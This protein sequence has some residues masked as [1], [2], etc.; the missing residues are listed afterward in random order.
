MKKIILVLVGFTTSFASILFGLFMLLALCVALL[1]DNFKAGLVQYKKKNYTRATALFAA[2][3]R[4]GNI[5][6]CRY[7]QVPLKKAAGVFDE[8]FKENMESTSEAEAARRLS[9]NKQNK[10]YRI[11][12]ELECLADDMAYCTYN[13]YLY[14]LGDGV[15]QNLS[16]AAEFY[17][18][19]CDND[20]M[21]ACYKLGSLYYDR[22]LEQNLSKASQLFSKACDGGDTTSC[23]FAGHIFFT[24]YSK[25][26]EPEKNS[27]N[28]V[29]YFKKG[30]EENDI[31]ACGY[32]ATCYIRGIGVEK[33]ESNFKKGIKILVNLCDQNEPRA[34][35]QL[36]NFTIDKEKA[37][38]LLIK[39]CMLG[40]QEACEELEEKINDN[41]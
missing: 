35:H 39:S 4:D 11:F 13:G 38:E 32:L 5:L 9:Q 3:C 30:C 20:L 15:D 33:N 1:Q 27:L 29:K 12:S 18:I 24:N 7:K 25:G 16:K 19:A 34:C 41:V 36:I 8:Y 21:L 6:A 40:M 26:I 28:A 37:K 14:E 31:A 22:G 2:S 10:E 17:K 23:G